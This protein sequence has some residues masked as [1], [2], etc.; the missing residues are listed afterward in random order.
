MKL[1]TALVSFLLMTVNTFG[2]YIPQNGVATSKSEITAITNAHIY[3]SSTEEYKKASI[4]IQEGKVLKIGKKI[5]IPKGAQVID[6]Q[7]RT[8][9]PA[10]IELNSNIGIVKQKKESPR[11]F[12]PQIESNKGSS[13]YWNEAVHPEVDASLIYSK[14]KAAIK[15]INQKGF[16]F[17]ASHSNEGIVR[18][19]GLLVSA[20]GDNLSSDILSP[21]IASFY[22][23]NKGDS[24]QSYPSSQ[25][26]SIALLRQ[27][28]YDFQYYTKSDLNFTDLSMEAWKSQMH[29]P[30]F[31]QTADKLEILRA[32]KIA[33]EFNSSFIY[34]G[35]GNEYEAIDPI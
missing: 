9:L 13:F 19:T 28:F 11:S 15:E 34:L 10:F 3:V 23:L 17:F 7:G 14:N 16:G 26:G 22:S 29:L 25:M 5:K 27:S 33:N 24:K 2:Q 31:F 18:G 32:S 4:L 6:L 1:I 21:Q 8:I 35:S 12:R 20:N 30:R